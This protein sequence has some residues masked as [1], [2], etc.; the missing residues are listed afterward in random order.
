MNNIGVDN[1]WANHGEAKGGCIATL[2]CFL[3]LVVCISATGR[4]Q[5]QVN[6]GFAPGSVTT[7]H[8]TCASQAAS[9]PPKLRCWHHLSVKDHEALFARSTTYLLI[10]IWA[11]FFIFAAACG[12]LVAR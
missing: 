11:G 10:N 4:A 6:L 3:L 2:V 9:T 5:A 12:F 8:I 1:R 7:K